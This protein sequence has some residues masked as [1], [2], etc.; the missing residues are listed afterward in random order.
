MAFHALPMRRFT[1]SGPHL[2]FPRRSH[3]RLL[4]GTTTEGS[5]SVVVNLRPLA[6]AHNCFP[7][8]SF[9][10]SMI[11]C[12][13]GPIL[14]GPTKSFL[15]N[16][17]EQ[18]ERGWRISISDCS[19]PG[20]Q[21]QLGFIKVKSGALHLSTFFVI[22]YSC[23]SSRNVSRDRR[24]FV[25]VSENGLPASM[26]GKSTQKEIARSGFD[27]GFGERLSVQARMHLTE[28]L[29]NKI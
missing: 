9:P 8:V 7:T 14:V 12:S 17:S 26:L 18:L 24:C 16:R 22:S 2:P 1:I 21:C 27:G 4:L 15:N 20:L 19:S 28:I 6:S 3:H 13:F 10:L 23:S 5:F 25:I 29:S 11:V